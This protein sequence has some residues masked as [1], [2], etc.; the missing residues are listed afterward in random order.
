[1][2]SE[3]FVT[4]GILTTLVLVF[5]NFGGFGFGLVGSK[6]PDSVKSIKGREI[7]CKNQ[8][9]GI[10]FMRLMGWACLGKVKKYWRIIL[11]PRGSKQAVNIIWALCAPPP[12]V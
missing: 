2:I 9:N 6:S 11:T 1:M 12:R 8:K 5:N 7:L 4:L 10:Y 3:T